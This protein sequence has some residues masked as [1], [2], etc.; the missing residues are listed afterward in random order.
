MIA[1]VFKQTMARRK[2]FVFGHLEIH[3]GLRDCHRDCLTEPGKMVCMQTEED[4]RSLRFHAW[5]ALG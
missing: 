4:S 2:G 1:Y 3:A 5:T